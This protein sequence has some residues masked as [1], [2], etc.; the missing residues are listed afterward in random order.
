MDCSSP[1]KMGCTLPITLHIY[2]KP[3]CCL[4]DIAK[5]RLLELQDEI[6]FELIEVDI[7]ADPELLTR[8]GSFIPVVELAGEELCRYRVNKKR[9]RKKLLDFS[10]KPEA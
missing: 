7:S 3:D 4:C 10:K 8:Y 9:V 2:S 6:D 5:D 1:V